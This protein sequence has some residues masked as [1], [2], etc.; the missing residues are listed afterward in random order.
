MNFIFYFCSPGYRIDFSSS[1]WLQIF[2]T[3]TESITAAITA[4]V[5]THFFT[6]DYIVVR[7]N[8]HPIWARAAHF[9]TKHHPL[10]LKWASTLT[11]DRP[12]WSWL[13][14]LSEILT[15]LYLHRVFHRCNWKLQRFQLM[16]MK[17]KV[18]AT[19][20]LRF[21]PCWYLYWSEND[22]FRRP[23]W[24]MRIYCIFDWTTVFFSFSSVQNFYSVLFV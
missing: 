19:N 8:C 4:A 11:Q 10:W 15:S 24:M 18:S 13:P 12:L 1:Q 5:P 6:W 20:F 23:I 17:L 16:L 14:P 21:S 2:K 3:A 7:P 22:R 9:S